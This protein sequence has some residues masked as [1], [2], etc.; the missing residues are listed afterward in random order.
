VFLDDLEV[1]CDAA[2]A[3]GMTAVRFESAEQA[4]AELD[5]VLTQ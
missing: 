4:I 2:R 5:S 3:I 1:N